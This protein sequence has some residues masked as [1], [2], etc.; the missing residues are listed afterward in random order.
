MK[1]KEKTNMEVEVEF[2]S[3]DIDESEDIVENDKEQPFIEG[4]PLPTRM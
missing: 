2:T 4:L 1:K 3:H